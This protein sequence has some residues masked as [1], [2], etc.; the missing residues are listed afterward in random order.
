MG[1]RNQWLTPWLKILVDIED[2]DVAL[3]ENDEVEEDF[4]LESDDDEEES[5]I[6][7]D[8]GDEDEE[9]KNVRD[10]KH[11]TGTTSELSSYA[12]YFF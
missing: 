1:N 11:M 3:G 9:F 2:E 5:D 4:D 10:G 7:F 8:F 6:E 12:F